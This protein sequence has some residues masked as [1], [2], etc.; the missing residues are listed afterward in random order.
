MSRVKVARD[1]YRDY[2]IMPALAA[3]Q[4]RVAGVACAIM[5]AFGVAAT[6][7]PFYKDEVIAACLLHDMG[8]ILKFDLASLPEF[9]EP[10]GLAYWEGVK[11]EFAAKYGSDEHAATLAIAKEIGVSARTWEY[12]DAVGFPKATEVA[13]DNSL[14]KKICCYADQRVTPYGV[15]SLAERF[16][17]AS[18]R[19]AGRAHRITDAGYAARQVSALGEMERQIFLRAAVAPDAITETVCEKYFPMLENF[20]FA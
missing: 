9:L 5:E 14:E 13:Q 3:H 17:E 20:A 19:Y 11:A 10:E 4:F 2:K 16:E 18:R 1:I 7:T 15:V 8:N 12:I 6:A